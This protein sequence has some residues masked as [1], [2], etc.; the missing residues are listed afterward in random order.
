M[1]AASTTTP[2]L[3]ASKKYQTLDS[4]QS[5]V[6]RVL[7]IYPPP[8]PINSSGNQRAVENP[9]IT[10]RLKCPNTREFVIRVRAKTGFQQLTLYDQEVS[11]Q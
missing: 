4:R 5:L 3:G 8:Q 7:Q 11:W 1:S 2:R 9:P 10:F 6:G